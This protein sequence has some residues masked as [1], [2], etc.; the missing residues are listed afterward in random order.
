MQKKQKKS[1]QRKWQLKQKASGRCTQCGD[2]AIKMG[3]CLIHYNK[4]KERSKKYMR[5][6]SKTEKWKT[7]YKGWKEKKEIMED[8]KCQKPKNPK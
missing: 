3:L 7:Y 8:K 2:K 6:Y 1:R 5:N 4:H